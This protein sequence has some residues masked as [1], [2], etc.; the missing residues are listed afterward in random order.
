M[1]EKTYTAEYEFNLGLMTLPV[2]IILCSLLWIW[3]AY[4]A[5]VLWGWFAV[6]TLGVPPVGVAQMF[7]LMILVSMMRGFRP[8][9]ATTKD[10]AAMVVK[11][12]VA[13]WFGLVARLWI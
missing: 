1:S 5:S 3:E 11:P 4:A 7:G 9:G 12:A 6:P 13:L 10:L 2:A 8:S